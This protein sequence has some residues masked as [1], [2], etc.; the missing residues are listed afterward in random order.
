M[1]L[2]NVLIEDVAKITALDQQLGQYSNV[3]WQELSDNDFVE[4]QKHFK[5]YYHLLA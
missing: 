4:A 1:Q 2:N 3:N 5:E